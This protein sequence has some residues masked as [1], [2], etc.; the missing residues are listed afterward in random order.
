LFEHLDMVTC[1]TF[2]TPAAGTVP[3]FFLNERYV[4]EVFGAGAGQLLL[5]AD[6]GSEKIADVFARPD[7]YKR[8]VKDIRAE[9]AER[10]S[11]QARLRDLI[12][13]IES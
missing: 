12:A 3:L 9:F 13:I 4:R 5:S 10:H 8:I 1:R 11:P 7:H 2:E 6:G